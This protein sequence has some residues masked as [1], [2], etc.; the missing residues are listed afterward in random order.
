MF[1]LSTYIAV[2]DVVLK[3]CCDNLFL[4]S[5]TGVQSNP[6]NNAASQGSL[7]CVTHGAAAAWHYAPH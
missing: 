7:V 3:W 4:V 1:A 2:V 5:R 6:S